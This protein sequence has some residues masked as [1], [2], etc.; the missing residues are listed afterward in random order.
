MN[1]RDVNNGSI[2]HCDFCSIVQDQIPRRVRYRE[3]GL[4]V[5]HNVLTWAPVML[6]VLPETHMTQE[7]FWASDLFSRA[8]NLAVHLG[9]ED[10]PNGYRLIANIG[11]DALQTQAHAH[12][13]VVGGKPL[14]PY[15]ASRL[16]GWGQEQ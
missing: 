3:T 9:R 2:L 10:C 16:T 15:V 14:G 5:I 12:I 4:I 11:N 6:L 13:H 7:E 8:A 1:N